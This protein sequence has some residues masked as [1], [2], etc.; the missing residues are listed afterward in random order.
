MRYVLQLNNLYFVGRTNE[1]KFIYDADIDAAQV[2]NGN[3][4]VRMVK[5][6]MQ[7][8]HKIK[9]QIKQIK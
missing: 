4:A 3:D 7:E 1:G 5:I 8:P 6:Y 9:F 2:F